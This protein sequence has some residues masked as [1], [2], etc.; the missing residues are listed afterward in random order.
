MATG[1]I[2]AA[3]NTAISSSMARTRARRA[4]LEP[5]LTA[6]FISMGMDVIL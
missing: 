3:A 1:G 5:A 6:G 2:S 4:M